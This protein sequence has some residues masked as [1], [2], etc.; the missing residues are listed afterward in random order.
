MTLTM[1]PLN[2]DCKSKTA[3]SEI[4]SIYSTD[5]RDRQFQFKCRKTVSKD[6]SKCFWTDNVNDFDEPLLFQCPANYVM[7]G[8]KSVHHNGIEK[9]ESGGL[10]VARLVT[11]VQ[12]IAS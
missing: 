9:I 10:S 8:V 1:Q 12:G 2:F 3:L 7:S 11:T 5:A 4:R 6:F